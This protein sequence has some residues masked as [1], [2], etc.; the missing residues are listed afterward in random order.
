MSL[1]HRSALLYISLPVLSSI[2][3]HHRELINSSVN[4]V[5]DLLTILVFCPEIDYYANDPLAGWSQVHNLLT[6]LYVSGTKRAYE[7]DKHF[8]DIDVIFEKWCGYQIELSYDKPFDV[9]FGTINGMTFLKNFSNI[10][11]SNF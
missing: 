5:T 11:S 8:L 3:E 9:L 7:T 1:T 2:T 10:F 4:Q 6:A